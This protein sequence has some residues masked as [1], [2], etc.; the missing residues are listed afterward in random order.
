[1]NLFVLIFVVLA[2]VLSAWSIWSA[3]R[4]GTRFRDSLRAGWVK[5]AQRFTENPWRW[6]LR[7]ALFAG[8]VLAASVGRLWP[9]ASW[10]YYILVSVGVAIPGLFFNRYWFGPHIR[11]KFLE[12]SP[13]A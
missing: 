5:D 3:R 6:S 7:T 12:P 9:Q 13:P 1:M 10:R 11:R 8:V 2:F 4:N